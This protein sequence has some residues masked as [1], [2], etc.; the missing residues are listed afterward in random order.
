MDNF[1]AAALNAAPNSPPQRSRLRA[2]TSQ[3]LLALAI[4]LSVAAHLVFGMSAV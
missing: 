1:G 4:L 2:T 3:A